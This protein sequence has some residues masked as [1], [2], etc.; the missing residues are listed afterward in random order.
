MEKPIHTY[1]TF[2][3]FGETDAS[4]RI[5]YASIYALVH[6]SV[7]DFALAKNIYKEWF[8]NSDWVTPVR[9][10]EAEYLAELN[11][12]SEVEVQLFLDRIGQTSFTWRFEVFSEGNLAAKV[13]V[14]LSLIHI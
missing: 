13:R 12:G 7:E 14:T 6:R 1:K 4:K 3:S 5:Y 2:V 11:A 9:H 10:S 8:D